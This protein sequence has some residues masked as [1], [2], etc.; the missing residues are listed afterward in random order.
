MAR[1]NR[2]RFALLGML[3]LGGPRS[4]YDLKKEFDERVRHFWS[5]SAGQIYP[6]LRQLERDGMVES[7]TVAQ[8]RRPDRVE[9]SITAAGRQHFRS[10]MSEPAQPP[11]V[12][13]ELL[14]KLF[15][16]PEAAPEIVENHL[17]AHRDAMRAALQMYE[18]FQAQIF[19]AARSDEQALYWSITLDA[20]RC[21]AEARV[22]WAEDALLAIEKHRKG[23]GDKS[24][25][26]RS[27][28][29]RRG[30]RA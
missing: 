5:E 30:E 20:G 29:P 2:T 14:L 19:A 18:G 28:A 11:T 9:Y 12:R 8:S 23:L 4:G 3:S 7:E 27:N 26:K 22:R 6:T 10:W 17:R 21:V 16:G 15:F 25:G 13:N 1:N 24:R